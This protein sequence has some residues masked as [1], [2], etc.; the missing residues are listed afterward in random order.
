MIGSIWKA[1]LYLPLRA[2]VSDF[3]TNKTLITHLKKDEDMI[4]LYDDYTKLHDGS[5][6]T[7]SNSRPA[8]AFTGVLSL[9]ENETTIVFC[10]KTFKHFC[11]KVKK[12]KYVKLYASCKPQFDFKIEFLNESGNAL[13][14]SNTIETSIT[15]FNQESNDF[16][17]L[18]NIVVSMIYKVWHRFYNVSDKHQ[19][20]GNFVIC[21]VSDTKEANAVAQLA[22]DAKATGLII[23][24]E[25][26]NI[27]IPTL[28]LDSKHADLRRDLKNIKGFTAYFTLFEMQAAPQEFI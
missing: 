12:K 18:E 19:I 21:Q 17:R 7:F 4:Y 10:D 3:P 5:P 24:K 6:R 20:E 14:K 13:S 11:D 2:A 1:T 27:A 9:V 26:E 28:V 25:P 16:P 22:F 8:I 23:D 15:F